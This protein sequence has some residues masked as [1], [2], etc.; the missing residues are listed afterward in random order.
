MPDLNPERLA[1]FN[2]KD[3][4]FLKGFVLGTPKHLPP[5]NDKPDGALATLNLRFFRGSHS[6]FYTVLAFPSKESL[7]AWDTAMGRSANGWF[8][9]SRQP[10]RDGVRYSPPHSRLKAAFVGT[11]VIQIGVFT[12]P[13]RR[14]E[15]SGAGSPKP[16]PPELDATGERVFAELIRRA[17]T[18]TQGAPILRP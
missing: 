11:Y 16:S 12:S 2:L 14:L 3:T 7:A 6:L 18:H 5:I 1:A 4:P 8:S 13:P 17:K 15:R 9:P 10:E